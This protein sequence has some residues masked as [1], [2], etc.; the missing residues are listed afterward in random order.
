MLRRI[1]RIASQ[2][3][4]IGQVATRCYVPN[5]LF[6]GSGLNFN[7]Q[8]Y[9]YMR[10][11]TPWVRIC[12]GGGWWSIGA[13]G[14][15]ESFP[16]TGPF[17]TV[18]ASIQYPV[19]VFTQAT[20]NGNPSLTFGANPVVANQF[21]DP[22]P[23]PPKGAKFYT[24]T[25]VS[26]PLGAQGLGFIQASTTPGVWMDIAGGD[27]ARLEGG[28]LT[29]GGT[30]TDDGT[31]SPGQICMLGII[32]LTRQPSVGLFG[33]SRMQGWFDDCS[34]APFGDTGEVARSISSDFAYINSGIGSDTIAGVVASN[35]A[36]S[37]LR[38]QLINYCSHIALEYGGNDLLTGGANAAQ[39]IANLELVLGMPGLVGKQV[40]VD[41]ILPASQSTDNW[42]TTQNQTTDSINGDRVTIN[43]AIRAGLP[44]SI[45]HFDPCGYGEFNFQQ[46]TGLW[47]P[48]S[49]TADGIHMNPTGYAGLVA[50]SQINTGFIRLKGA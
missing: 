35:G 8:Q 6:N 18:T 34:T 27:A 14:A 28:D 10:E 42:A 7:M 15:G 2:T 41:T 50:S 17:S 33:D 47:I 30:I 20:W 31:V 38:R 32:G 13:G 9:H 48:G 44:G 45:G 22:I 29:L 1:R 12:P 11:D 5:T 24:R 36:N 16:T 46:G 3:E 21:S 40:L 4:Y 23:A 19:G 37:A 39:V 49:I 43:A 26:I 25:Y